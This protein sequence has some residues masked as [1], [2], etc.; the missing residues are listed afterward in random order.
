[1]PLILQPT[2][3][4]AS[5]D[6]IERHLLVVRA[7]RMNAVAT[8]YAGVN[9]K[10]THMIVKFQQ[11]LAR[12]YQLLAKDFDK[13]NKLEEALEKRLNTLEQ[14]A[15]ERDSARDNLVEIEDGD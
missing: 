13:M 1:M 3:D 11:R 7:R 5:R 6:E 8:Y 10:T 4:G 9:A 12:E 14:L 2:Y 15:H